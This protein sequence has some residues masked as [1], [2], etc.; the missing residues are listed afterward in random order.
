MP[1]TTILV[2][3]KASYDGSTLMARN[4]DSPSGKFEP[5]RFIV[6]NPEDQPRHYKAVLVDFEMDLPDN[7]MRYTAMPNAIDKEGIWGEAGINEANVAMSETETI[8]SNSRVLGADPLVKNGISEEDMLTI[9]LPYIKS[10][11]EGVERLGS[12][13]E[14]YGTYEMNGIGFQDVDEIWW[15]ETIGGHHWMAKR[16]PDDAYVVGPNQL[17]IDS[18]DFKDALG[19]KKD[20]MCSKDLADFVDENNLNLSKTDVK[21]AEDTAFDA[22]AAF[23][24]HSDS[25]HVYNTPRAW[26]MERYLNPN[27]Y[28]W[29]G[30]DADFTPESDDIPWSMV[31][32]K[33]ITIEDIKYVLSSYYQGTQYNPYDRRAVESKKGKYRP[34]GINRNNFVAI[35]QI[36]PYVDPAIAGIE[37]ISEG[38]NAFNTS[39]P[40]YANIT[41]TP[42]YLENAG[43]LVTTENFYWASRIIGALADSYY[44]LCIAHI[45]R[46]ELKTMGEGHAFIKRVDEGFKKLKSKDDKK[47]KAYLEKKND[48]MAAYLK[49]ETYKV[50][51][52]VLYTASNQMKNGF[53]MNDY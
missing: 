35:T 11:R 26:F 6:V 10:A 48:E 43:E 1:C 9:V 37:W 39:V 19:A 51:D 25:D 14:K 22:R 47:V 41:K 21:T 27:T 8:T 2:G 12:I 32:E 50:L 17:G 7:P 45:E 52:K 18:F 24:S 53:S 46:Y 44:N 3:K 23:G 29:D 13:L 15:L 38:S 20:H 16:V 30:E 33:K 5:K 36:R 31:P 28:N 34:I 40:F 42:K 49:D 4:E